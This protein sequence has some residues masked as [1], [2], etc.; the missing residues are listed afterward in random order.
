MFGAEAPPGAEEKP[1]E[2]IEALKWKV[3]FMRVRFA[4]LVGILSDTLDEAT[5]RK[6]FESMGRECAR[7]FMD[8]TGKFAGHPE[9]F[10]EEI[11]KRW[12]K[13]T[14]YDQAAG[15]IRVVDR[16]NHCTCAFV[17]EQLT[18][19]AFCDCTLGWQK[20]TYAMILGQ[21]VDAELEESILRG[22]K[23]CSYRIQ[24]VKRTT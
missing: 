22:G 4:K 6:V 13:E 16:S 9:A 11:K 10:L 8:L 1:N 15:R 24:A 20:E 23:Q 18:P 12:A 7:Q 21:P 17:D 2:E 14:E 3:N 19:P 5:R